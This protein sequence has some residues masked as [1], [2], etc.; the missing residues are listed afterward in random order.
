MRLSGLG[1]V[2]PDVGAEMAADPAAEP[3]G[4][5]DNGDAIREAVGGDA[6]M[7]MAV[8]G[9]APGHQPPDT[10]RSHVAERHG[11]P[12]M[13]RGTRTLGHAVLASCGETRTMSG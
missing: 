4:D 7:V 2:R 5:G 3:I 6:G 11:R 13:A 12:G 1:P 9:A 10:E 8:A